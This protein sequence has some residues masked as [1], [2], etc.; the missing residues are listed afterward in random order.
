GQGPGQVTLAESEQTKPPRGHHEAIGVSNRLGNPAP[1]FP[2]GT[3]FSERA[4]L[5][6]ARG[7]RGAAEHGGGGG[8]SG[9]PVAPGPV[10][11]RDGLSAVVNRPMIVTLEPVG[12][13]EEVVRQCLQA[14]LPT[15]RGEG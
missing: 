9:G 13:A 11:E 12:K 10:E 15:G 5:G 7:K 3:A 8:G 4:Q 6:M 2:A 14:N 1:L